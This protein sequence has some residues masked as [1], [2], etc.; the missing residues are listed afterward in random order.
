MSVLNVL[1][2]V[3]RSVPTL[4]APSL[5]AV[6]L[7]I[8]PAMVEEL[9]LVSHHFYAVRLKLLSLFPPRY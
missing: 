3:L 7:D 1:I 4:W 5:V 6:E 2:T 9:V 8:V